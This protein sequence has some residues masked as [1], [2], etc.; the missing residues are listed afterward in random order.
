MDTFLM[1]TTPVLTAF[2]A[3]LEGP[4]GGYQGDLSGSA[5]A[6]I[7]G[8]KI[9]AATAILND[10]GWLLHATDK[11]ALNRLLDTLLEKLIPVSIEGEAQT[12]I[13]A[14]KHPRLSALPDI[15]TRQCVH[16]ELT[17]K[18]IPRRTAG[19]HKFAQMSDIPRLEQYS[20][21]YAAELGETPPDDWRTLTSENRI[22]LGIQ[23]GT[24]ASVAQRGATTLDS[25]SI[26]GVYTFKPYRRRGMAEGLVAALARQAA[27]RDQVAGAIVGKDNAPMLAL[28]EGLQFNKTT[29]YLVA[30]FGKKVPDEA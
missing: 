3:F 23:E 27:G 4:D 13:Q 28:L 14:L 20:S 16:L 15:R 10:N 21:E 29:E 25:V 1:N 17:S 11:K 9:L 2:R 19:H 7:E 30:A 22:L 18:R 24:I 26:V 5:V 8:D 6:F 12:V